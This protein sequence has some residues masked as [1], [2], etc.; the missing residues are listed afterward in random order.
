MGPS[1]AKLIDIR[2]RQSTMRRALLKLRDPNEKRLLQDNIENFLETCI[3]RRDGSLRDQDTSRKVMRVLD[4]HTGRFVW[5]DPVQEE[6]AILSHTWD[7]IGE[8][9][10]SSVRD[11]QL[12]TEST[13]FQN[14]A[15]SSK[16]MQACAIARRD[17][18][19]Y[20]WIDSCCIDKTSSSE[21]SEA[22]N[23][24]FD[25]YRRAALCYAFLADVPNRSDSDA[26]SR[27][28]GSRWFKRG[29]TLQE[30]IAPR[31]LVFLSADWEV[32]GTKTT[33][34]ATVAKVTGVEEGV[35]RHQK[36][37]SSVPVVVRMSWA[38][39]RETTRVEDR[40]Y[41]LF[42]IFNIRLNALYGEGENAFIRLQ[43][44]IL[45]RIPDQTIF[46]WGSGMTSHLGPSPLPRSPLSRITL[47]ENAGTRPRFLL[48]LSPTDFAESG[49]I[50][51][52]PPGRWNDFGLS[53]IPIP[54][55][56]TSPY[57]IR[58]QLP[59]LPI[60]VYFGK[61]HF[62]NTLSSNKAW[63]LAIFACEHS[64]YR[65]RV[66]ARVC[67][68]KR[69]QDPQHPK[70]LQR[71]FIVLSDPPR[72]NIRGCFDMVTL[73]WT[74]LRDWRSELLVQTVYIPF[75]NPATSLRRE[76]PPSPT[77]TSP[78]SLGKPALRII[79]EDWC[80]AALAAQGYEDKLDFLI[81]GRKGRKR[82]TLGLHCLLLSRH[83]L[84]VRLEFE[85]QYLR[86]STAPGHSLQVTA[87]TFLPTAP[88]TLPMNLISESDDRALTQW[89][90]ESGFPD[91]ELQTQAGRR[92][93]L[94]LHIAEVP[95]KDEDVDAHWFKLRVEI[96]EEH[97]E[98][99]AQLKEN[100]DQDDSPQ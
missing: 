79:L 28:E 41:S 50:Y 32:F 78:S 86:N 3:P 63:Y 35:L 37:L 75:T 25:W 7:P 67:F 1:R 18:F 4:T 5:I 44:E 74:Q 92:L 87:S 34:I 22:I 12:S 46:A 9:T 8:Q 43:E 65:G 2:P 91:I 93:T 31:S 84:V 57:G 55:F 42:G 11:L 96:I 66:L 88:Q 51:P 98:N 27:F 10:Y 14:Q 19:R 71:G 30:L 59:L 77:I 16:V 29:W 80:R 53:N 13:L 69:S 48:P 45:V 72:D 68:A 17:G 49:Q 6:Y 26:L 70:L 52:I 39:N 62:D 81:I 97:T 95:P 47:Y 24:M 99:S 60:A 90:G 83:D 100:V 36:A 64:S 76:L 56:T 58:T 23:S 15:L 21:L 40:A 89:Y 54:E 61:A 85:F 20:I 38:A 82:E 94:V 73:D 33:L